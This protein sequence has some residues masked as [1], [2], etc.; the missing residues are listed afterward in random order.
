MDHPDMWSTNRCKHPQIEVTSTTEQH[1]FHN[2]CYS[3]LLYEC[4][5]SKVI[6]RGCGCSDEATL[7]PSH[8]TSCST[9]H[10]DRFI[11]A[12][13]AVEHINNTLINA[14]KST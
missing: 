2:Y 10:Q 4:I 7:L 9:N 13:F 3:D 8:I 12:D 1:L 5:Y 14:T 11:Y 6:K